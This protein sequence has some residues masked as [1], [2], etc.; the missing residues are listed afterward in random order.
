MKP[1][2]LATLL[3]ASAAFPLAFAPVPVPLTVWE[4]RD[5]KLIPHVQRPRFL[6][7]GLLDNTPLR[8]AQKLLLSEGCDLKDG[9][10]VDPRGATVLFLKSGQEGWRRSF[11]PPTL[12]ENDRLNRAIREGTLPKA[13]QTVLGELGGFVGQFIGNATDMEALE[14]LELLAADEAFDRPSEDGAP[15]QAPP[16]AP[17]GLAPPPARVPC[18]AANR[19]AR[20]PGARHAGR[21]AVPR[22]FRRVPR[23]RLSRLRFLPG[24]RRR[25]GARGAAPAPEPGRSRP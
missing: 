2:D 10:D 1:E 17:A 23:A 16:P 12:E 25:P 18:A 24:R 5:D 21:R 7:G 4:A 8:L 22:P 13:D 6:D 19:L 3:R 11:P 14:A 15:A 9:A 20:G